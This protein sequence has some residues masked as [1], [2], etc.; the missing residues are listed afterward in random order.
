MPRRF[1]LHRQVQH[2]FASATMGFLSRF[3][4]V[5]QVGQH[6]NGDG[7]IERQKFVRNLKVA[8]HVVDDNGGAKKSGYFPQLNLHNR[9]AALADTNR[10]RVQAGFGSSGRRG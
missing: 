4:G 1:R 8:P 6:R 10:D 2:H 5:L 3:L 7:I 9:L